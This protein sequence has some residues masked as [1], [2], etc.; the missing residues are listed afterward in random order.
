LI[1]QEEAQNV[2]LGDIAAGIGQLIG[3]LLAVSGLWLFYRLRRR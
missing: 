3:V 1:T 2:L